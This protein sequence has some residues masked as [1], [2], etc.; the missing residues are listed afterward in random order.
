MG[1]FKWSKG[2]LLAVMLAGFLVKTP[3]LLHVHPLTYGDARG[4]YTLAKNLS[5]RE[6]FSRDTVPPYRPDHF[7]TPGY[8]LFLASLYKIGIKAPRLHVLVNAMLSSLTAG[9]LYIFAGEL[10]GWLWVLN[11]L[12]FLF[13]LDLM[14]ES[15]F[16]L[17][18][19]LGL[20]LVMKK[21]LWY[22]A[23]GGAVWGYAIL[24]RPAALFLPLLL[25]WTVKGLKRKLLFAGSM[26][27]LLVPWLIR[28]Q[29]LFGRPFFSSVF[30]YNIS[31]F[32][33]QYCLS[34]KWKVSREESSI[35]FFNQV[36][37]KQGWNVRIDDSAAVHQYYI[38]PRFSPALFSESVREI[39]NDPKCYFKAHLFN[40][41]KLMF[42]VPPG[43]LTMLFGGKAKPSG[44]FTSLLSKGP[45]SLIKGLRSYPI[46]EQIFI[47]YAILFYIT[48]YSIIF[49]SLV[50]SAKKCKFN[51][52]TL[53]LLAVA[54]Y[55]YL[56]PGVP[57]PRLR[58]PGELALT[59]ML[60]FWD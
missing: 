57:T 17:L 2:K 42:P 50:K 46:H 9:L 35:R 1:E 47:G 51:A 3:F 43:H 55:F 11:P 24:T 39:L 6:V 16:L 54:L 27:A 58:L 28:N 25:F 8:P 20:L 44:Y 13:S 34:K 48:F 22:S 56:L 29:I 18:F 45:S 15:T 38:D 41:L 59:A 60:R 7:R 23:L 12:A 49:Y 4:Y 33:F 19:I 21:H 36:A 52:F 26:L 40:T 32:N 10:A 53:I 30:Y 31:F 5:E 14:T 37:E